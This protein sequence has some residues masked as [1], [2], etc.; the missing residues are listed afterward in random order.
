MGMELINHN[1]GKG[2]CIQIRYTGESRTCHNIIVDT[3]VLQ[4]GPQLNLIWN[5][6]MDAREML[7]VII[8]THVDDDHIGGLLY[9]LR[10][11]NIPPVKEIWMNHGNLM[12]ESV[13][14]S[15]KQNDELYT[16]LVKA[17]ILVKPVIAGMEKVLDGAEFKIVWPNENILNDFYSDY[18][19]QIPL[20]HASD[21]GYSFEE[22]K[23][24]PIS[25][26][27]SRKCNRASVIFELNYGEKRL[28][29][30]GDAWAHDIMENVKNRKYDFIKLP[31]HGSILNLSEGWGDVFECSK[32]IICTDGI[33]H[34]N[35]QTIAKLYKWYEEVEIYGSAPW[36][37]K[38]IIEADLKIMDKIHFI[39][40]KHIWIVKN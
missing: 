11:G 18:I 9:N 28:L 2:D 33:S 21:Y 40:D 20:G 12:R 23:D 6:I 15:V 37:N 31:H 8:L 25:S 19:G 24:M 32:Y 10:I 7:D 36:W 35:K 30:T 14:L 38:M 26:K 29:F 16:H 4:F 3:G 34:P 5:S 39:G 1:A 13:E 22:L 27:D 17:G